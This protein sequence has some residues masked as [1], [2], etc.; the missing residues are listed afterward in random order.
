MKKIGGHVATFGALVRTQKQEKSK[1]NPLFLER[2]FKIKQEIRKKETE[3]DK[4]TRKQVQNA[5]LEQN[6][7]TN[8]KPNPNHDSP[9]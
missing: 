8:T 9:A 4:G 5:E 7:K 6:N 3:Q 1:N 2:T